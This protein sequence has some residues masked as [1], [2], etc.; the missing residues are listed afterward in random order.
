MTSSAILS[1]CASTS[2][3]QNRSTFHPAAS[4]ARSFSRS[5][6]ALRRTLATQYAELWPWLSIARRRSRSR[7]CQ[8]S[9][10][11][12]TTRRS[13]GNTI[14]GRPGSPGTWMRYRKPRRQSSRR[15]ASSQRVFFLRLAPRAAADALSEAGRS[16]V[17][18]GVLRLVDLIRI[19]FYSTFH[20][21]SSCTALSAARSPLW[22]KRGTRKSRLETKTE[23]EANS[24]LLARF[25]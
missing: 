10:S 8:K 19:A 11:Q 9:P 18:E 21:S 22:R 3:S 5:R 23:N 17:K 4:S 14:S 13:R 16:P 2:V 1:E 15:R 25:W 6:S 7:P 20:R 12:K 24:A